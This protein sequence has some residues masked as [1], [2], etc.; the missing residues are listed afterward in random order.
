[1]CIVKLPTRKQLLV[2]IDKY[3][4]EYVKKRDQ[5]WKGYVQCISC[6]VVRGVGELQSGHYY[7]R[8]HDFTTALGGC[9]ENV[10]LQCVPC[11]NYKRGNPHGYATGL[12]RKYGKDILEKLAEAKKNPKKWKVSE[13]NNLLEEYKKKFFH[14]IIYLNNTI[15]FVLISPS[16]F[17]R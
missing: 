17:N 16:I 3:R 14:N 4:R 2:L 7:S 5:D 10:N 6:G 11:N 12:G 9:D 1:M 8:T 15:F 13:L